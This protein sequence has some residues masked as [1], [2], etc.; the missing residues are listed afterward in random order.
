[1]YLALMQKFTD[2]QDHIRVSAVQFYTQAKVL[3]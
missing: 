2:P 1:M 3:Y